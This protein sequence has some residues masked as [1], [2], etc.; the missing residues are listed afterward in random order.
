MSQ[1]ST[2]KLP[3]TSGQGPLETFTFT[4]DGKGPNPSR[5]S[6]SFPVLLDYADHYLKGS[7]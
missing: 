5:V 2:F 1:V 6:G 4:M 3:L 7:C